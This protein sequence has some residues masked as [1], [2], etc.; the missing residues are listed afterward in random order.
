MTL[1]NLGK[2]LV[3]FQVERSILLNF[4]IWEPV[5]NLFGLQFRSMKNGLSVAMHTSVIDVYM[6]KNSQLC[7]VL[8]DDILF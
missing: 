1:L 4:F 3:V 6:Y 7:S 2:S 8:C 5:P